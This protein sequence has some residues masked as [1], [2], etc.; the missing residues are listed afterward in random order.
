MM[1]CDNDDDN[2]SNNNN[3]DTLEKRLVNSEST[4]SRSCMHTHGVVSKL[5][6]IWFHVT[7]VLSG[8]I[9]SQYCMALAVQHDYIHAMNDVLV[10]M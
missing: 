7:H 8:C 1:W 5:Y 9:P 2:N 6:M 4:A 3:N 10:S